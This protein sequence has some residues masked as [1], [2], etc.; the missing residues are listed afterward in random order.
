MCYIPTYSDV[1]LAIESIIALFDR[2]WLYCEVLY[3]INLK[4]WIQ[5]LG[6]KVVMLLP[7]SLS[8]FDDWL[9]M[10]LTR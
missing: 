3:Q 5:F 7:V 1:C 2:I 8:G 9:D 6:I 10:Y 4:C